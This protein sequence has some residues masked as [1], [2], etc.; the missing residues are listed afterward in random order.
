MTIQRTD[1]ANGLSLYSHAAHMSSAGIIR[2][3][4]TSF[5]MATRLLGRQIRPHIE[6]IYGLV[7]I[8]DE[9]VDGAAAAAGLDVDAQRALLDALEVE[10]ETTLQTGYSTNL[11]VHSF[12][13]TARSVGFGAELTRPFFASMRRDLDP[14]GFTVDEVS[15]YIYG[16]AEVIGLMCL[17]AFLAGVPCDSDQRARLESGARRLGS[18]FQK[19]N[20]LRDLRAD[21]HDLGRNYFPHIDPDRLTETQKLDLV[22]DIEADLDAAAAVIPELPQNCRV[23]VDAAHGLFAALTQR[24]RATPAADLLAARIRVPNAGKLAIVIAATMHG[25]AR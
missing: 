4:S 10:T 1:A 23:A 24:L 9:V 14:A 12:A 13:V 17:N 18:A 21:W 19:I 8:A 2:E 22:A 7:R 5:G 11:T 6:N 16:S 25:R 15:D 3:Y 20:F